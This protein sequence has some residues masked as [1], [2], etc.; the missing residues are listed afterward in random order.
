VPLEILTR[1]RFIKVRVSVGR[2]K[3]LYDK[4]QTLEKREQD[5]QAQAAIKFN[6]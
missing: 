4:R 2:G 1:G 5:R 3:K 6:R